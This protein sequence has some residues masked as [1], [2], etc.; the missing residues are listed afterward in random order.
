[1]KVLLISVKSENS[2]G[3]VAV[4]TNQYLSGCKAT[5]IQ[6]DIVN[7]EAVGKI[8]MYATA[9][10]NLKD[11]FIRT[12][13]INQQLN[14]NL[15]QNQSIMATATPIIASFDHNSE[16]CSILEKYNAGL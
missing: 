3:G 6:C 9:K 16:L 5:G 12:W 8:A 15:R 7:I 10:R 11:E 14:I 1:M 13:R 2:K 4:W